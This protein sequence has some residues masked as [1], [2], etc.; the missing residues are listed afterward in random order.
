MGNEN[1]R[2]QPEWADRDPKFICVVSQGGKYADADFA[3]GYFVGGMI[4]KLRV[5]SV[6]GTV[7]MEVA[8]PIDLVQQIDLVA[9]K[10]GFV[11]SV[12]WDSQ[13]YQYVPIS[14]SWGTDVA[15]IMEEENNED[16]G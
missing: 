9:M 5:A 8:V 10:F 16:E 6:S 2:W 3:A 11:V 7:P 13:Y 15:E 14:F 4:E 12:D 1:A